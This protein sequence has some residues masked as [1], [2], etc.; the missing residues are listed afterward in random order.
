LA[1]LTP[2]DRSQP[3]HIFLHRFFLAFDRF[4]Q[5]KLSPAAI[6]IVVRTM[7]SKVAVAAQKIRQKPDSY[8]E[9][10]EFSRKGDIG[11]FRFS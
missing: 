11:F 8:F 6:Q 5:L 9:G 10:N 1:D 7:D 3:V 2:R 4:H